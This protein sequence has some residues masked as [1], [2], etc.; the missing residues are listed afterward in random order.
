MY[1]F[2]GIGYYQMNKKKTIAKHLKHCATVDSTL[3]ALPSSYKE[4]FRFCHVHYSLN[5]EDL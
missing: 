5:R 2:K 1:T 3:L 4:E